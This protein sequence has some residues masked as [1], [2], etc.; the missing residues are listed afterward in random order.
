MRPNL[1]PVSL[2]HSEYGELHQLPKAFR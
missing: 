2:V 1:F